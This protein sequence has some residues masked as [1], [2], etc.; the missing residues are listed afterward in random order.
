MSIS[1]FCQL[2]VNGLAI[3]ML[4]VMIVVGME[5]ILRGNRMV[6]FAHGQVYMLGAYAFY[7]GHVVFHIPFFAAVLF[8]GFSLLALGVVAYVM[9]FSPMQKRITVGAPFS[10]RLLMS[11]M[12][13]LGLMMMLQQG[14]LLVFGTGEKGVTSVYPQMLSYGEIAI[15]LERVVIILFSLSV[16]FLLYLLFFKTRI[17]KAM[18]AVSFDAEVS[19]LLGV[20]TFWTNVFSFAG[21]CALAGMAGAMIAPVAGVAPEMGNGVITMALLIMVV[22]GLGSYKGAVTGGILVGLVLSFGFHFLGGLSELVFFVSVI[23]FVIFRPG[24]VFGEAFD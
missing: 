1:L 9:V 4:Y 20:N 6:N 22:G 8:A 3:G 14:A 10:Y 15:S 16:C 13:S 11:A 17:G 5:M 19:S 7:F 24:G 18:R 2:V 21:G 23:V 12:T